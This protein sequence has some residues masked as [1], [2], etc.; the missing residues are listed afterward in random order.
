TM[1]T[2]SGDS[3]FNILRHVILPFLGMLVNIVIVVSAAG[4][5]LTAGGVITQATVIA[6][7]LAGVWLLVNVGYYFVRRKRE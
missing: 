3:S 4:I 6:F 5:G 7:G 1:V 2:F